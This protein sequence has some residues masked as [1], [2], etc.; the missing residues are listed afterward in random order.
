MTF[1]KPGRISHEIRPV[2]MVMVEKN[3]YILLC[4]L[5]KGEYAGYWLLPSNTLENGLENTVL[6]IVKERL[7]TDVIE[8]KMIGVTEEKDFA[9]H[10]IYRF[11]FS[12]KLLDDPYCVDDNDYFQCKWF[13]REA[14]NE[15][16]QEKDAVPKIGIMGI[17]KKWADGENI[18]P[19]TEFD[20]NM[21][22]PCGSGYGYRGCCGWDL[23]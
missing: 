17:I 21:E 7:N 22:C 12:A 16:L 5:A 19:L 3:D 4:Q 13:S 11:L 14:A 23:K 18:M 8:L 2:V 1:R 20:E 6:N 10:Y 9:Q 15:M